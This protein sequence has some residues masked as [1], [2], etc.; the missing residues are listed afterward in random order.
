MCEIPNF[1]NIQSPP[2]S[3]KAGDFR[4]SPHPLGR[5]MEAEIR[6]PGRRRGCR[7]S[8]IRKILARTGALG[9]P[10]NPQA[11][12]GDPS[13]VAGPGIFGGPGKQNIN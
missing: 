2:G 5:R 9:F 13:G 8:D 1:L 7:P 10:G 12:R 6:T 11:T 4:W 3:G